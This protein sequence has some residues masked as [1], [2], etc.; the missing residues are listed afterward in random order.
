MRPSFL[1]LKQT[2]GS[3]ALE[4]LFRSSFSRAFSFDRSDLLDVFFSAFLGR[5]GIASAFFLGSPWL[6]SCHPPVPSAHPERPF[7]SPTDEIISSA[8]LVNVL[9]CC[10]V[11]MISL[12]RGS[13]NKYCSNEICSIIVALL[14]NYF[15]PSIHSS[16]HILISYM[17]VSR[18]YST[19]FIATVRNLCTNDFGETRYLL[20]RLPFP[21]S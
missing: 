21:S 13:D 11:S 10:S 2:D 9:T 1:Q 8:D 4:V 6:I 15:S 18:N 12:S 16:R 7:H 19:L 20:K 14:R 3:F 5:G 17:L